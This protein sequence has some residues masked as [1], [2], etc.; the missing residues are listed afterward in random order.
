M[1]RESGDRKDGLLAFT[2]WSIGTGQHPGDT[3]GREVS[4]FL[5][6]EKEVGRN[7]NAHRSWSKARGDM[8]VQ[9]QRTRE[10][11]QSTE[12]QVNLQQRKGC[13]CP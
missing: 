5:T 9:E 13:F 10:Q 1:R 7:E 4:E 6:S 2:G 11:T 12:A 3:S 8:L